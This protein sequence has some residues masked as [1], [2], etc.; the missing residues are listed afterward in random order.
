MGKKAKLG[1]F[2]KDKFYKL[3]KET[4]KH[5][6][7]NITLDLEFSYVLKNELISDFL[8]LLNRISI[9]CC[10]QINSIKS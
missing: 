2:R 6:C 1:K 3:A 7:R 8:N 9:S 4:G 10:I 5:L